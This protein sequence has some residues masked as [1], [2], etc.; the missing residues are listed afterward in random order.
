M[1]VTISFGKISQIAV[2]LVKTENL[3]VKWIDTERKKR[4]KKLYTNQTHTN[5]SWTDRRMDRWTEGELSNGN[6]VKCGINNKNRRQL[7]TITLNFHI[8]MC[9]VCSRRTHDQLI[10]TFNCKVKFRCGKIVIS[11]QSRTTHVH[12]I[13][14]V[15][16]LIRFQWS[17][18][19]SAFRIRRKINIL[20]MHSHMGIWYWIKAIYM[21]F[22]DMIEANEKS[23]WSIMKL[24]FSL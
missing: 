11:P 1:H 9:V 21:D 8:D 3:R 23:T 12:M 19:C 16:S 6:S 2:I 13:G 17:F 14:A 24:S 20:F 18:I 5:Y 10:I 7:N 15:I 4:R 22:L